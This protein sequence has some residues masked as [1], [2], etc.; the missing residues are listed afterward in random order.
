MQCQFC[1]QILED[2]NALQLHQVT[3]CPAVEE[4]NRSTSFENGEI[5]ILINVDSIYFVI[6]FT[7]LDILLQFL[8][9]IRKYKYINTYNFILARNYGSLITVLYSFHLFGYFVLLLYL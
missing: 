1:K 2:V 8:F 7:F 5:F 6:F 4:V 9:P 3:S